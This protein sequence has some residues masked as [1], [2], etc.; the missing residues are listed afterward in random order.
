MST[1]V[2]RKVPDVKVHCG[3]KQEVK[4]PDLCAGKRVLLVSLPGAFTPT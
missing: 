3:F 4:V 1:A 2:G